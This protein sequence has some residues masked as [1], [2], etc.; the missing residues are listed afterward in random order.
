L[1]R[2][3]E[4]R[5]WPL[6]PTIMHEKTNPS[7]LCIIDNITTNNTHLGKMEILRPMKRMKRRIIISNGKNN[8]LQQSLSTY[9]QQLP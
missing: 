3:K 2:F 6:N 4:A 5:I 7:S 9:Q 8:M 1:L